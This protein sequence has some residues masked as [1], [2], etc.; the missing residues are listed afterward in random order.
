MTN[1]VFYPVFSVKQLDPYLPPECRWWRKECPI[2]I[3]R[4]LIGYGTVFTSSYSSNIAL[5]KEV[6]KTFEMSGAS[7]MADSGGFQ[8]AIGKNIDLSIDEV[9]EWQAN[10]ADVVFGLDIPPPRLGKS[11]NTSFFEEYA[12][13]SSKNYE[14]QLK[15]LDKHGNKKFVLVLHGTSKDELDTWWEIAIK[16]FIDIVDYVAYPPT[17]KT[18]SQTAFALAYMVNKGVKN[19]HILAGSG[20]RSTAVLALFKKYFKTF[21]MDSSSFSRDAGWLRAYIPG[22]MKVV[23]LG[24]RGS[25]KKGLKEFICNCPVCSKIGYVTLDVL[26][27]LHNLLHTVIYIDM[28]NLLNSKELYKLIGL[29]KIKTF[30]E[31]FQDKGF[32]DAYSFFVKTTN[33]SAHKKRIGG[34]SKWL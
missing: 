29:K 7:V 9:V 21:T 20:E 12:L 26:L 16:P 23:E 22:T 28:V 32:D 33:I 31:L 19:V 34:V 4:V 10:N 15:Y 3:P 18:A 30:F 24:V 25:K 2:Y 27:E 11:K 14:K 8:L 6:R 17:P 5:Y 1:I 13:K